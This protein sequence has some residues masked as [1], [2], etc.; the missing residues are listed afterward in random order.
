MKRTRT[1]DS[2]SIY[3][4]HST[5]ATYFKI[6]GRFDASCELD[7]R[8]GKER[9]SGN[10][11]QTS[12]R[13]IEGCGMHSTRYCYISGA[14]DRPCIPKDSRCGHLGIND[15]YSRGSARLQYDLIIL[16]IDLDIVR[17]PFVLNVAGMLRA[18]L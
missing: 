17:I 16:K 5:R 12:G 11:C 15:R 18:L 10:A 8:S 2:G 6:A 14:R 4:V 13:T 9:C 7:S 1:R 3:R